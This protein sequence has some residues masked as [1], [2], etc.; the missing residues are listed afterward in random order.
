MFGPLSL[1]TLVLATAQA[2]DAVT[3]KEKLFDQ[4]KAFTTPLVIPDVIDMRKGGN[5]EMNIGETIH[6]W[7]SG[8]PNGTT[9]GYGK[10][11]G[12]I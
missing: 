4:W 6:A 1:V 9:Y 3:S 12:K 2:Q 5:L 8:S 7:G 10:V 11:G